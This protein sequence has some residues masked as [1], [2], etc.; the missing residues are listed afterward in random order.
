MQAHLFLVH[1]LEYLLNFWMITWMKNANNFQ[2]EKAIVHQCFISFHE[3]T[4]N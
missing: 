1:F 3:C 2:I 4:F